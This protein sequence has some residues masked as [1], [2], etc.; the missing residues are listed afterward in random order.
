MV[1]GYN[2]PVFAIGVVARIVGVH[3]QTLRIYERR[4]L[5]RPYR[6]RGN[7]RLYSR[8]DIERLLKIKE[9]IDDLGIN[10]AGVEVLSRLTDRVGE[11]ERQ[12][13]ELTS[14]VVRLR[15]AERSLPGPGAVREES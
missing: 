10:L 3:P 11:L 5:I 6:S 12:L 1:I 4:E 13:E 15:N 14:E 9:W 7:I 8:R 2:E